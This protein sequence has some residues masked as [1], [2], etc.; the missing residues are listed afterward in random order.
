MTSCTSASAGWVGGWRAGGGPPNAG[1]QQAS[2]LSRLLLGRRGVGCAAGGGGRTRVVDAGPRRARRTLARCRRATGATRPALVSDPDPPPP[3]PAVRHGGRA[4]GGRRLCQDRAQLLCHSPS[5]HAAAPPAG[6][7]AAPWRPDTAPLPPKA[8][9][10]GGRAAVEPAPCG[11]RGT[12]RPTARPATGPVNAELHPGR[13]QIP[14][15]GQW[16]L[17]GA[18]ERRPC[19][20][21]A[22]RRS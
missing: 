11:R 12:R 18:R 13:S 1:V 5:Q 8:S 17:G 15:R 6:R 9:G 14:C 2:M 7:A 16:R 21:C 20:R 3:L 4:A 19:H 10:A 22:P